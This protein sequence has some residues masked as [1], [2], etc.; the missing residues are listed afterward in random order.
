MGWHAQF[1]I[2]AR[3]PLPVLDDFPTHDP[4]R[5]RDLLRRLGCAPDRMETAHG[6]FAEGMSPRGWAVGVGAYGRGC[7]VSGNPVDE[8]LAEGHPS[9]ALRACLRVYP[10]AQALA[11]GLVSTVNYFAYALYDAEAR[12]VRA[13]AG[14]ADEGVT[15]EQGVVQPEEAPHFA[16]SFFRDGQRAFVSDVTGKPEEFT[17]DA[18][19]EGLAFAMCARFFGAPLDEFASEDLPMELFRP[20]RRFPW[21]LSLLG[22]RPTAR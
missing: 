4:A 22:R 19:G 2:V 10:G 3:P 15:V 6:T 18:L 21:P 14:S 16:G 9:Y 12:P 1:L 5:A 11:V 13:Y 7:I 17:S 20:R 8:G